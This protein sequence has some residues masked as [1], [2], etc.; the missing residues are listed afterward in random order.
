[1]E[2]SEIRAISGLGADFQL[3]N[4]D[5]KEYVWKFADQLWETNIVNQEFDLVNPWT[6]N[7]PI[8]EPNNLGREAAYQKHLRILSE[9]TDDLEPNNSYWASAD[10]TQI[11][12]TSLPPSS[13]VHYPH[14]HP[15]I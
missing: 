15:E 9:I 4:T 11:G 2:F 3:V 12:T 10:S 7:L 13:P 14:Q 8:S 5:S 6:F 1:M